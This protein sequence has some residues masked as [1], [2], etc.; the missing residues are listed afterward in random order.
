MDATP[1]QKQ[2]VT[3]VSVALKLFASAKIVSLQL[4]LS[5]LQLSTGVQLPP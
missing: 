3:D 4:L 1:P 2:A 5:L